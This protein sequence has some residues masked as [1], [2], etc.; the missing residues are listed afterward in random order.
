MRLYSA[1]TISCKRDPRVCAALETPR[2][3][4]V[5]KR[6]GRRSNGKGDWVDQRVTLPNDHA[7]QDRRRH[8]AEANAVGE[9]QIA[10]FCGAAV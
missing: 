4:G 7:G 1:F 9:D 10:W 6:G 2:Q 3:A 8:I 5:R